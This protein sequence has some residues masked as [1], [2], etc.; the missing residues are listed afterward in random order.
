MVHWNHKP[1][2]QG[3]QKIQYNFG[4]HQEIWLKTKMEGVILLQ[5]KTCN[6]AYIYSIG[7]TII[8]VSAPGGSTLF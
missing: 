2:M 4:Y 7:E 8:S 1:D 5:Y 6:T 3:T